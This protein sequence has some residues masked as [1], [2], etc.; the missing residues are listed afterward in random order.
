MGDIRIR[1]IIWFCLFLDKVSVCTLGCLETCYTASATQ[2]LGATL[3]SE[4]AAMVWGY[5]RF[6]Y[7]RFGGRQQGLLIG[8]TSLLVIMKQCGTVRCAGETKELQRRDIFVTLGTGEISAPQKLQWYHRGPVWCISLAFLSEEC[9]PFYFQ[10]P[11]PTL[12]FL[13]FDVYVLCGT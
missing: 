4:E 10:T 13:P 11:F 5:Y 9:L 1:S 6:G 8:C 3:P 7:Y 12:I 2:V